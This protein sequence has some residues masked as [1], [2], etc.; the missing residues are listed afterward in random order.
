MTATSLN[1]QARLVFH[2]DPSDNWGL[3]IVQGVAQFGRAGLGPGGRKF[4]LSPRFLAVRDGLQGLLP[5]S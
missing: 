2:S 5:C 3:S 1:L 4:I